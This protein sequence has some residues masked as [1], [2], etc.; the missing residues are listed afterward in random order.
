MPSKTSLDELP[1]RM[2]TGEEQAYRDFADALGPR[3][4][5]YFMRRGLNWVDAEDLAVSC[6]TDIALKVPR[7]T[8]Q[9][10]GSFERWAF[11]LAHNALVDWLRHREPT[12]SLSEEIHHEQ[13]SGKG[14]ETAEDDAPETGIA[15]AVNEVLEEMPA[16]DR[17]IVQLRLLEKPY[18]FAE[19]GAIVGLSTIAARVRYHRAL[20]RLKKRL[21]KQPAIAR[22]LNRVR[23]QG[24]VRVHAEKV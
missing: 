17:T 11:T 13:L 23:Y 14:H 15:S 9:G 24:E 1:G 4:R 3:F 10:D 5:A 19:I 18:S 20:A 6:V 8:E 12:V 21:E 2:L 22:L 7:F 16:V